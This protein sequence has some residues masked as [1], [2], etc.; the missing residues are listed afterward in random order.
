MG[1]KFSFLFTILLIVNVSLVAQADPMLSTEQDFE[2]YSLGDILPAIAWSP[3]DIESV[4][5]DDPIA[6]GNNVLKN[7]VH[8]YNAA[9]VLTFVLP[10]GKTLADYDSLN[11][12]AYFHKG[13][14]AWKGIVVQAYQTKPTGHF[15]DTDTLGFY[16]RAQGVSSNWENLSLAIRNISAFSDTIYIALGINCAG[17]ANGDTT[18][19]YADDII[20]VEKTSDVGPV[21]DYLTHS[22]TFDDGTANDQVG[23]ADGT[24]MGSASISQGALN[25]TNE[26]SYLSLPGDSIAIN[27]YEEI[28]I[29]AWFQSIADGNSGF[30][31]L[32]AFGNTPSSLGADYYFMTPAREDDISRAA[33]SCGDESTPWSSETGVNGVEYDDGLVHHLVSTIN[34]DSIA[35]YVDGALQAITPLDVNN[36]LSLLSTT[37]AYLA[38]SVYSSDPTWK[39]YILE[40]NMYNKAF[41]AENI[42]YLYDEGKEY[43]HEIKEVQVVTNG[44]FEDSHVGNVDSMS[45]NGWLFLVADGISPQPEFEVVSDPVQE[46]SRALKVT[47][48]GLGTDQWDTQVVAD[49]IHV[50]PGILYNY[51]IW[52]KADQPGAQVNFTVGSYTSGEYGAIRPANLTTSWKKYTMTFT[53]TN[54]ETIIRGPIHF[55]YS[56]NTD[57]AIYIDDLQIVANTPD[58]DEYQGPPLA[59]NQPKFVGN[60]YSSAQINNFEAYWNQVTPENA[61]KWGSVE[62]TRDVMNW[63]DLDAAYKLAKDNNFP[64]HFHV[65]IWGAQQPAWIDS[66][67]TTEQLEEIREWFEEVAARFPEIDYL[68]VVNEPLSGHNPPDGTN[69]RANY[70]AALGGNGTSGW[71]WVLNAF[72]MAR[73][74]FPAETKLMLNDFSI[75]NTTSSTATYLQIINLLKAENLIDII[76][77][78]GH[79]FTTTAPAVTMT[80]NLNSLAATGLPIQITELDIDGTTDAVQLQ[81]Y[82]R[83]FP[84]LYEHPG[85]E[86]ITLW[87][88]R[89]GLWRDTEGAYL[90][91]QDGTE[92]AALVWLRNY[93]DSV[94]VTVSVEKIAET[95]QKFELCNNYPN[96]FNPTTQISYSV[97]TNGYVSL[98]VYNLL[99]EEI[100]TLVDERQNAGLYV[101]TFDGK[102]LASGVYLY[103]LRADGMTSTKRFT[104]LK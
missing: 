50:T 54:N 30:S 58:P 69:G 16:N 55:N 10:A 44:G 31:M 17:T 9:P 75:I 90:V 77:E 4:V 40:F 56:A 88:W 33:I 100:A 82:Q 36:D 94:D 11:F 73:E 87:G 103:Q 61:G 76:A 7:T 84:T 98:K 83:I 93:L 46:G 29:E 60:V 3:S 74:I 102:D 1:S 95:A 35:L 52:A 47:V 28:T 24:T 51:S 86:G 20:L 14:V 85:V 19:W 91:N 101:A 5:A 39:G 32:A 27:T 67:S 18:T 89:R 37:Y 80:K 97:P 65:L 62:G 104:L 42:L 13:D 21:T 92:R 72:R 23:T 6:S 63:R 22:W 8:N 57:N 78:Q 2:T 48:H 53:V 71:D 59:S 45:V 64:F 66:L 49:S 99:G 81:S 68:E 43:F 12:K 79:A 41:S 38:K 34:S 26:D 15:L 25:T 70:K 96:P